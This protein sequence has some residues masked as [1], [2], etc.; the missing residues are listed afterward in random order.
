MDETSVARLLRC[1]WAAVDRTVARVVLMSW[2]SASG[3]DGR[4]TRIWPLGSY[5]PADPTC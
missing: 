3:M 5:A 2:A 1:S 4:S